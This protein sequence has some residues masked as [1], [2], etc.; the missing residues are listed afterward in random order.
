MGCLQGP[1]TET[2]YENFMDREQMERND[3]KDLQVAEL[4]PDDIREISKSTLETGLVGY[5]DDDAGLHA[6]SADD[7][8][9]ITLHIYSPPTR[10]STVVEPGEL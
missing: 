9:C 2:L 6:M 7:G 4:K 1:L 10:V 5:I 8:D 3:P